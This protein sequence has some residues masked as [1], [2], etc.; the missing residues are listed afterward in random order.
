MVLESVYV[1]YTSGDQRTEAGRETGTLVTLR[2]RSAALESDLTDKDTETYSDSQT[3][4]ETQ[5]EAEAEAEAETVAVCARTV[6]FFLFYR[7][8]PFCGHVQNVVKHSG[9]TQ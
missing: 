1:G 6:G 7:H 5:T 4:T 2:L 3:A 9:C 8:S